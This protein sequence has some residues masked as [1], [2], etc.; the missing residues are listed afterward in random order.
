MVMM[1]IGFGCGNVSVNVYVH[2]PSSSIPSSTCVDRVNF[3]YVIP[4]DKN[5]LYICLSSCKIGAV[6]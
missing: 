5:M 4:N 3:G 2:L 1:T 6:T